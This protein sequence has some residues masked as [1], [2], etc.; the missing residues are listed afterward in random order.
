MMLLV[1]MITQKWDFIQP[2]RCQGE[3]EDLIVLAIYFLPN[4]FM[5][6][7]KRFIKSY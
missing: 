2:C 3:F 5:G 7:C 1:N 6:L 4:Y